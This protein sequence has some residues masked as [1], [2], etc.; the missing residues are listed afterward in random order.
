MPADKPMPEQGAHYATLA[1]AK[2]VPEQA[3]QLSLGPNHTPDSEPP[4][5]QGSTRANSQPSAAELVGPSPSS[6]LQGCHDEHQ[7]DDSKMQSSLVVDR[8]PNSGVICG[9]ERCVSCCVSDAQHAVYS[10]TNPATSVRFKSLLEV[11]L[12]ATSM[13]PNISMT[14]LHARART[15]ACCTNCTE[16]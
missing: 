15:H 12:L 16:T 13:S 14:G 1:L 8:V 11:A 2:V 10:A 3:A 5:S 4:T 7:L 9:N 6:S